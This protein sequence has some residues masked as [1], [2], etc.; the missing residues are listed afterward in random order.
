ML[1]MIPQLTQVS[2]A[3]RRD[4]IGRLP[5]YL[6][7]S[8]FLCLSHVLGSKVLISICLATLLVAAME[9][10]Y[11]SVEFEFLLF[12]LPWSPLLKQQVGDTSFF[13]IALLMLCFFA[14][15]RSRFVVRRFQMLLPVLLLLITL[16]AKIIQGHSLDRSYLLYFCLLITFPCVL[17]KDQNC[18]E[19]LFSISI[20]FAFGIISA[21]FSA[22]AAAGYPNISRFINVASWAHVTRLSG[23]YGDA[24]FYS[25]QIN[26]CIACLL[27]VLSKEDSTGLRAGVIA[28]LVVLLYCGLLSASKSFVIVGACEFFVWVLL[29]LS[30]RR[31]KLS[32][33]VLLVTAVLVLLFV[34]STSAFQELLRVLDDRFSYAA[35]LSE[36]T[37]GRT[38]VWINYLNL[39][40]HDP[41]VALL[42]E[43]LTNVT[44][45]A[46]Y[47]KA[48]HNT[49][50]QCVFQFGLIGTPLIV[51]WLLNMFKSTPS[52][53]SGK[54]NIMAFVLLL[55]GVF[56]PWFG[57]DYLFFDE[58]F[59]FPGLVTKCAALVSD[60]PSEGDAERQ[61]Q[62]FNRVLP[63][64]R[65]N[66]MDGE[67]E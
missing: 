4:G 66:G 45:D 62:E 55:V 50:I 26:A 34:L 20:F 16:L 35:S 47:G 33:F 48:S 14:L 8:L 54:M 12:F 63:T 67:Y 36:V 9:A 6:G 31:K 49:V 18:K 57:L 21:A 19:S 38:D 25:A 51:A 28:L 13:T 39:F 17:V 15:I 3:S 60:T 10:S 37:T 56:L 29:M 22:Q 44:L 32:G 27:V 53:I 7:I 11:R 41:E 65:T 43:G 24:N 64:Q 46:L 1:G 58:F 59:L 52:H 42:G 61:E 23:Y 30:R 40:T 2:R 5:I